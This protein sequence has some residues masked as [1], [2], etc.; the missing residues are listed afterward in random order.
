M[1]INKL[2]DMSFEKTRL[3]FS[4]EEYLNIAKSIAA[5]VALQNA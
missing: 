4:Q 2:H 3:E 1:P 5:Y